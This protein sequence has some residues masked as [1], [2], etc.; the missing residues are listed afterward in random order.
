MNCEYCH[1]VIANGENRVRSKLPLR[2]GTHPE[3]HIHLHDRQRG[4]CWFKYL[5]DV[6]IKPSTATDLIQATQLQAL[7]LNSTHDPVR[8][9]PPK[10]RLFILALKLLELIP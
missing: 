3:D 7:D 8:R 9:V 2:H 4:D 10:T 6:L 1:L 5:R